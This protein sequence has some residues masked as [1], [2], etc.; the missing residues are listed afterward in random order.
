VCP[1]IDDLDE[2]KEDGRNDEWFYA[3]Y[4]MR[5]LFPF[6]LTTAFVGAKQGLGAHGS[7]TTPTPSRR[8]HHL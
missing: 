1:Q 3:I 4:L 6:I 7:P 8:L 5:A 2:H